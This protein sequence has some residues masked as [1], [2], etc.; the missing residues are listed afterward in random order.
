MDFCRIF[1]SFIRFRLLLAIALLLIGAPAFA[2]F[3]YIPNSGDGTVS[4]IDTRTATAVAT[5]E[6]GVPEGSNVAGVAV[7]PDGVEGWVVTQAFEPASTTGAIVAIS[8]AS[9]VASA[10]ISVGVAPQ[11]IA[12]TPDG[13]KAYVTNSGDNTVSVISVA[14]HRVVATIPVGNQPLRVAVRPDGAKVYVTNYADETVSVISTATDRVLTTVQLKGN[15]IGVA[16]SPDGQ[17]AYVA[18]SAYNAATA[19]HNGEISV[20]TTAPDELSSVIAVPTTFFSGSIPKELAVSPDGSAAYVSNVFGGAVSVVD[21]TH[22]V[23]A[24][25]IQIDPEEAAVTI[26]PDG[27]T[28]YVVGGDVVYAIDR[29]TSAVSST[30]FGNGLLYG[31]VVTPDGSAVCAAVQQ[32]TAGPL[33][34]SFSTVTGKLV[35]AASVAAAPTGVAITPDG[36]KAYVTNSVGNGVSVIDTVTQTIAKTIPVAAPSFGIVVSPDGGSVYVATSTNPVELGD[37][38]VIDT[39]TDAIVAAVQIGAAATGMAISPDG[40]KLYAATYY[41]QLLTTIDTAQRTIT[42][43]LNVGLPHSVA[44]SPDGGTAYVTSIGYETL[45]AVDTTSNTVRAQ[46][47]VPLVGGGGIAVSSDGGTVYVA[48]NNGKVVE[49]IDAATF[50]N[51]STIQVGNGP[52]GVS[53]TSDGAAA[54]VANE[55][56]G[57]ISVIDTASQKVIATIPVG[58]APTAYGNFIQP[59]S[60]LASAILPGA[61]SVVLGTPATVFATLLN[62]AQSSLLAC[63]VEL[64]APPAAL[65]MTYQTTNPASNALTGLPNMPADIGPGGAQTFL[66]SFQSTGPLIQA[67]QPI[68]FSCANAPAAPIVPGVNTVDLDFSAVPIADVIAL[69]ASA[70]PGVVTI[71]QS[72]GAT[73][74][75]SV[76]TVNVGAAGSLGVSVDSGAASL[77]LSATLCPTDPATARCLTPPG[78]SVTIDF[79][80][81]ATSTFSIFLAASAPIPFDPGASR[82]FVRFKDAQGVAHGS[83]SLAVMTD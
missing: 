41:S 6:I 17:K 62:T 55:N 25:S 2:Q 4:V 11:A 8:L 37:I 24:S 42:G 9:G 14:L 67:A 35:A 78:A 58:S 54:Y 30:L 64:A 57:T 72:S 77:P 40:S 26:T 53:F 48:I 60:P 73:G 66:L 27:K 44:I 28:V 47:S 33:L 15:P 45:S 50:T 69:A 52:A 59:A 46:V 5:V 74:A 36:R 63:A 81:G 76:A 79:A 82:V 49:V 12:I 51:A 34:D 18:D 43:Q 65:S 29:A 56:D 23:A 71:P 61:R 75:F 1:T 10:P 19:F 7:T 22:E 3:A 83:T 80:A 31:M 70:Q 38:A 68:R 20:L 39:S 13:T 21:L 16:F 32:S